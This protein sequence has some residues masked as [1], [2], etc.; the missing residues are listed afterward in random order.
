VELVTNGHNH[1][2]DFNYI[3]SLGEEMIIARRDTCS[4][5]LGQA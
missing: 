5:S 3:T 2:I 4:S 1:S